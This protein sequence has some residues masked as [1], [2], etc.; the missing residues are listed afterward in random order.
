VAIISRTFELPSRA[1]GGYVFK[2]WKWAE[3]ASLARRKDDAFLQ[4]L[5]IDDTPKGA[6]CIDEPYRSLHWA[7]LRD[8]KLQPEF[9]ELLSRGIRNY[10][11]PR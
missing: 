5:V 4:P 1:L 8:S 3:D 10:R 11:R 9:I 7:E 6:K 2:E